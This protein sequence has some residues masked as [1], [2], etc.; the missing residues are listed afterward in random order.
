MLPDVNSARGCA[1]DLLLARIDDRHMHFLARRGAPLGELHEASWLQKSDVRHGALVGGVLGGIL[2]GIVA[3]VLSFVPMGDWSINHA[4]VLLLIG[5]GIFFGIW[6][7]TLVGLSVPNSRLTPFAADIE[8]GHVLLILDVPFQ[9]VDEVQELLK[10]KHPETQWG[11]V[12]PTV[13]AFP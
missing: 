9:R 11:G 13:P 7:A 3:V 12:D 5:F 2:G 1:N 8:N 6:A 10:V 4:G